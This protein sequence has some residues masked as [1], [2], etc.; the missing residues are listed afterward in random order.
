LAHRHEKITALNTAAEELRKG[1]MPITIDALA[2]KAS[3]HVP[4]KPYS[5]KLFI[6]NKMREQE[7]RD[8]GLLE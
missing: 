2:E 6:R 1:D 5:L 7:L 3:A 4:L 8:V